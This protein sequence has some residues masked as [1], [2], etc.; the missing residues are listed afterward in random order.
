MRKWSVR[1]SSKAE[2]NL[3]VANQSPEAKSHSFTMILHRTTCGDDIS[4][5]LVETHSGLVEASGAQD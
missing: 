5:A 2:S 4:K 3:G 1:K